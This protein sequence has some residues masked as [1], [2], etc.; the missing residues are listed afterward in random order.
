[1]I[2]GVFEEVLVGWAGEGGSSPGLRWEGKQG[3]C[4]K[5]VHRAKRGKPR[6]QR[7]RTL[8]SLHSMQGPDWAVATLR[9]S[10]RARAAKAAA[11]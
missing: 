7:R 4:T 8:Q 11:A 1:M 10:A 6:W 2:V 9:R 3:Q 5:A